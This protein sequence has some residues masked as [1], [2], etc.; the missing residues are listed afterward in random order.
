MKKVTSALLDQMLLD[1]EERNTPLSL[2]A[3]ITHRCNFDCVHCYQA[4]QHQATRPELTTA[5]WCRVLDE[6][7]ALGTFFL[8][9]SGGEMLV[10]RDWF[11]IAQHARTIGLALRLYTNGSLITAE[12]ADQ[13]AAL[14]VMGVEISVYSHKSA[15]FEEVTQRRGSFARTIQGIKWVRE[16]NIPTT[17]KT[18]IMR[19]N[20]ASYHELIAL[21][22]ELGAYYILDPQLTPRNDGGL[23]PL[24]YAVS[25]VDLAGLY[26]DPALYDQPCTV[27][28]RHL[29]AIL[30]G[31]PCGSGRRICV[32]DPYGEVYGCLQMLRSNGN[33]REQSL[34]AIWWHG[35]TFLET[36]SKRRKD[37]VRCETCPGPPYCKP[38]MGLS[39]MEHGAIL[40]Q[41]SVACRQNHLRYQQAMAAQ[42]IA[43]DIPARLGGNP[44]AGAVLAR[45]APTASAIASPLTLMGR[46]RFRREQV[47]AEAE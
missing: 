8:T 2:L 39:L 9:I 11:A 47:P 36:R 20:V 5:E 28:D 24:Q 6:A 40:G 22:E 29:E 35:A 30:N 44:T 33:V 38:C 46:E 21:A 17:I 34:G 15:V 1:A 13:M 3:E 16:R 42:G 43:V 37:L 23:E 19:Q 32:V 7:K 26:N 41:S 10:R 4:H 18:P 14:D 31:A 45:P 12:V 25:N 27:G